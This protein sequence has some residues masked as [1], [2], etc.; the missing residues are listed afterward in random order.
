M[1]PLMQQADKGGVTMGKRRQ[2]KMAVEI[3]RILAAIMRM[4]S[5]IP[6]SI[7]QAFL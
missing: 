6:A 3:K 2:E 1:K 4:I 5:R 7:F